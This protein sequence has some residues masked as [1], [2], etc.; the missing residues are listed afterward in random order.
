MDTI[1]VTALDVVTSTSDHLLK[2]AREG[3]PEGMAIRANVQTKGRGRLG[4]KWQSPRGNLYVSILLRP[5]RPMAEWPSLSL[6]A[7]IAL[8][9][10]LAPYRDKSDLGLK[11]PNDLLYKERKCAGLLLEVH[12]K[13]VLL[14]YGV[15]LN[16]IPEKVN[17]WPPVSLND[18]DDCMNHLN[19]EMVMSSLSETLPK[20]YNAWID[21]GFLPM[22]D[23]WL[24]AAAHY[25]LDLVVNRN[26]EVIEG[27]FDNL[28]ASGSLCLLD[29][30]GVSHVITQGEVTGVSIKGAA[31]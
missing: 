5:T 2:A 16:Q 27:R 23:D 28:E 22:R 15:N 4:R 8:F 14:G 13:A 26:D 7:G 19:P 30:D 17:G 1:S 20:R 24:S 9:D 11:W 18:T 21:G 29:A 10:A 31:E 3:A 6:V 25:G 12:D